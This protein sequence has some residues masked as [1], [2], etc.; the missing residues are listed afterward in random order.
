MVVQFQVIEC[1]YCGID[2]GVFVVVVVF[3]ILDYVDQF[4]VMWFI[5][6]FVQVMQQWCYWQVDGVVQGQ[7][8]Q[9]I[10]G[11]VGI[12]NVQGIGGYEV[13]DGYWWWQYVFLFVVVFVFW[14]FVVFM[15]ESIGQLQYV[16]VV[17][18]VEIV[19]GGWFIQVEGG[20]WCGCGIYFYYQG[21]IVIEYVYG[22]LVEDVGFVGG[23]VFYVVVLVQVVLG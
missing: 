8:G 9:C 10:Y 7:C 4:Y 3:D 12:V 15:Y 2:I 6:V 22:I 20:Q 1:G 21:I 23:V 5:G 18:Q 19:R 13:F 16:V 14:Y 11:V 17:D